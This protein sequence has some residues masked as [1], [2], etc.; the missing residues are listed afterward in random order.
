MKALSVRQPWAWAIVMGFKPIENRTWRTSHRGPLLIHASQ[1]LDKK[2][3][4]FIRCQ[5]G[6]PLPDAFDL[7]GI[8]GTVN[9]V[10]ITAHDQ[11]KWF[12]GPWGWQLV[13]P[14]PLPFRPCKGKLGIWEYKP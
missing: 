10:G 1:Q 5:I 3:V 9:L 8:V 11:S 14:K 7:G 13:K 4:E 6:I 2:G 12:L